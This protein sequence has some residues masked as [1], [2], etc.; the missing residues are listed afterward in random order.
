MSEILP[1]AFILISSNSF[2]LINIYYLTELVSLFASRTMNLYV[3]MGCSFC[4]I[5]IDSTS[6]Q[7]PAHP[8][9]RLLTVVAAPCGICGNFISHF[10]LFLVLLLRL[11]SL[12]W[13]FGH[14]VGEERPIYFLVFGLLHMYSLSCLLALLLGVISWLSFVIAALPEHLLYYFLFFCRRWRKRFDILNIFLNGLFK[15]KLIV[16]TAELR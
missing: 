16:N 5:K 8:S 1:W 10:V 11:L 9:D 7:P 4:S 14:L 3:T 15:L 12:Q 6:H 2:H 13:H